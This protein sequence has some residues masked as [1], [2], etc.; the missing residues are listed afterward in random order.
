MQVILLTADFKKYIYFIKLINDYFQAGMQHAGL[1][2]QMAHYNMEA[3][4]FYERY[5]LEW[6][7]AEPSVVQFCY[8]QQQAA[9]AAMTAATP[10]TSVAHFCYQPEDGE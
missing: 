9:V 1:E 4:A 8:Q 3:R 2:A 10:E 7:M 6:P 5:G